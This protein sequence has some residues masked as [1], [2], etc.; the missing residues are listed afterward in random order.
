MIVQKN[1]QKY[2]KNH[3]FF[4]YFFLFQLF[5]NKGITGIFS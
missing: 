2:S 4:S 3:T 5:F 1:I